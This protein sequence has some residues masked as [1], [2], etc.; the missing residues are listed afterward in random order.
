METRTGTHI[1]GQ[2]RHILKETLQRYNFE[3]LDKAPYQKHRDQFTPKKRNKLI[4][5]WEKHT[6][7]VWP[8]YDRD[9]DKLNKFG[10]PIYEKGD[11]YQAHHVIHQS[12]GGFFYTP[13]Q[14]TCLSIMFRAEGS[15]RKRHYGRYYHSI[16]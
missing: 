12:N 15:N 13:C 11:P 10:K 14:M 5:E 2:Q 4:S 7:Q 16:A 1:T 6:G 3:K 9:S 8:K